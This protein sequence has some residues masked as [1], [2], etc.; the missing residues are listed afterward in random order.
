MIHYTHNLY[1][2]IIECYEYETRNLTIY[3]NVVRSRNGILPNVIKMQS[4]DE[5][6]DPTF[7][8]DANGLIHHL[9]NLIER[10]EELGKDGRNI[11]G[12]CRGVDDIEDIRG[13]S[14]VINWM[15]ED[16]LTA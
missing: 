2:E 9:L 13:K 4:A 12:I 8:E 10:I 11:E 15:L 14:L 3:G 6:E 7:N 5:D 16:G 1:K